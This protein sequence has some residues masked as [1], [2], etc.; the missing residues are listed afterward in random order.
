MNR[1]YCLYFGDFITAPD[2]YRI[3]ESIIILLAMNKKVL[4]KKSFSFGSALDLINA[5]VAKAEEIGLNI[6]VSIVDESVVEKAFCRMDNAPLI[7]IETARKKAKFA[8]GF[9]MPTGEKWHDFIKDDIILS[10]GA[11]DLPGF[12]LLGGGVPVYHEGDLIG[13]IGIS[14][15]HYK[16]DELCANAAV[17][18]V[19]G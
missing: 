5:A 8:V 7:S 16:Q 9:G 14:G 2:C 3:F 19:Y 4:N 18:A 13:S 17:N 15:G 12:I 10:S 11:S 1:Y 6:S